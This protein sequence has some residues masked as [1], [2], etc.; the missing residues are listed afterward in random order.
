MGAH[1]GKR[2]ISPD[3]GV[4]RTESLQKDKPTLFRIIRS[5]VNSAD[6]V[7]TYCDFLKDIYVKYYG[8][9]RGKLN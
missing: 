5:V 3:A 8:V 1:R 2:A 4:L 9:S 6:T 7:V